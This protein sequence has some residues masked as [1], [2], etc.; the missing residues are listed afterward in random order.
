MKLSRIVPALAMLSA[1]AVAA[2]ASTAFA[3]EA[4]TSDQFPSTT[5]S[6]KLADPDDIIQDMSQ[7]YTGNS[8]TVLHSGNMTIGIIGPGGGGYAG[9]GP[10]LADP[11]MGTVPSKR[12]W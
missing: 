10:F 12:E 9:N 5:L 4:V 2:S 7:R 1:V 3:F 8:A 6:T 11:A